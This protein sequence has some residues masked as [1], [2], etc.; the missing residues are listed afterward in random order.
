MKEERLARS[1]AQHGGVDLGVD[2][3][4]RWP[5]RQEHDREDQPLPV[6]RVGVAQPQRDVGQVMGVAEGTVGATLHQARAELAEQLGISEAPATPA[7]PAD[8]VTS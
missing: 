6:D 3:D 1:A 4:G 7:T 2:L 8:G 5:D